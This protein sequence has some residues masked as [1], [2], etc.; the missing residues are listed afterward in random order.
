MQEI[1]YTAVG[2]LLIRKA[3]QNG[4]YPVILING[5]ENLVDPQEFAVWSILC[6][7]IYD[8]EELSMRYEELASSLPP[9]R[10]TLECCV[11]R[12]QTRGLIAKGTGE[13]DFDALYDLLSD[14]YVTPVSENTALRVAAFCKL[15]FC[16]RVSVRRAWQLFRR[17]R[18]D[19][20]EARVMALSGQILLTT[21]E[22]IK[23]A[24]VG[25]EDIS[26]DEKLLDAL[27][28]DEETT[29]DNIAM[30]MQ[31]SPSCKDVTVAVANLYLR[32]QIVLERV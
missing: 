20:Q 30:L 28:A 16:S 5:R 10:R 22:L 1:L 17:D 23:C 13:T 8:A 24:E 11:N 14:L 31:A 21:A 2:N 27:Y 6:W 9:A 15:V 26:T 32:K 3:E 4:K 7:R 18:R 19:V 12:L 29:S 25:V